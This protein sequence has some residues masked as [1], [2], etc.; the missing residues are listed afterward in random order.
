MSKTDVNRSTAYYA[1]L[2]ITR[3]QAYA[4]LELNNQIDRNR[5]DAPAFVRELVYTV[6][7]NRNYLDFLL[8]Q[9][10]SRGF[11]KLRPQPLTL[12]RMGLAQILYMDSVPDHAAVNETVRLARKHCVHQAGMINGVLRTYLRQADTL[13]KPDSIRDRKSVV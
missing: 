10:V 3:D 9:M 2:R 6:L 8:A 13:R 11:Q 4:N 1:L 12:L 5:P 7:R